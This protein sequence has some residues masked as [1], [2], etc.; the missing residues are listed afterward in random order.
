MNIGACTGGS[1]KEADGPG[2]ESLREAG[3]HQHAG[4]CPNCPI[5]LARLNHEE[6]QIQICDR[7]VNDVLD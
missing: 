4:T 1:K 3:A 6:Q 7:H 2:A 5:D